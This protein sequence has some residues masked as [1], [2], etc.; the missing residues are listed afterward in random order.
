MSLVNKLIVKSV[1]EGL[2]RDVIVQE[3]RSRLRSSYQATFRRERNI[4]HIDLY[5]N[6]SFTVPMG[7]SISVTSKDK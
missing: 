3:K 7:L 5:F 2:V 4:D 6:Q 1:K